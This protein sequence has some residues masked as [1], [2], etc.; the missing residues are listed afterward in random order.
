MKRFYT[1]GS[2]YS[3]PR[4]VPQLRQTRCGRAGCP[5]LVQVVR[6]AALIFQWVRRLSRRV[7]EI[8]LLGTEATLN[9]FRYIMIML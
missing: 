6:A 4:Y 2:T 9:S 7:R 3:R 5:Q 8:L 1:S